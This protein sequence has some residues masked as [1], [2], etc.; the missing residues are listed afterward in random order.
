MEKVTA[1]KAD[2]VAGFFD[3]ERKA[4]QAEFALLLQRLFGRVSTAAHTDKNRFISDVSGGIYVG[5]MSAFLEA[6]DYLREHKTLLDGH[7]LEEGK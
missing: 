6:A 1:F 2:G 7:A 3:T 4:R 5:A